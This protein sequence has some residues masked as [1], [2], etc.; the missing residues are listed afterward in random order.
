VI[1]GHSLNKFSDPLDF[2]YKTEICTLGAESSFGFLKSDHEDG[3][4]TT[5]WT[6][7]WEVVSCVELH[8]TLWNAL[9]PIHTDGNGTS[10]VIASSSSSLNVT[11]SIVWMEVWITFVTSARINPVGSPAGVNSKTIMYCGMASFRSMTCVDHVSFWMTSSRES[12]DMHSYKI[13]L[14]T[15]TPCSRL[16]SVCLA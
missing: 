2:G 10:M 13:F 5:L 6:F 4:Y 1:P 12:A 8:T 16:S 3:R 7:T 9:D 11:Q 15:V 14:P